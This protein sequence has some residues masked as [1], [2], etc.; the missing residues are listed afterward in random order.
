MF[1]DGTINYQGR[2]HTI[3]F[4]LT[5]YYSTTDL[6]FTA[7]QETLQL[8]YRSTLLYTERNNVQ[9]S[10]LDP[11][12]VRAAQSGFPSNPLA[13]PPLPI[14]S[15]SLPHLTLDSEGLVLNDDGT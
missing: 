15:T 13:D 1:R 4:V 5:P 2:Q 14:A 6:S 11:L 3:D 10:G 8:T 12:A 7:A 9:T